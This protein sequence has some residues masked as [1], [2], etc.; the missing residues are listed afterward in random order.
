MTTKQTQDAPSPNGAEPADQSASPPG[1]VLYNPLKLDTLRS[2]SDVLKGVWTD[3]SRVPILTRPEPN[4]WVR[5]RAGE[6]YTE[7]IDLLVAANA[8]HSSDRNPVYVATDDVRPELERFIKP[9]RVVVAITYHSKVQFLWVRAVG[10]GS[11]PWTDSVM[12]AMDE[13]QTDWVSLESDQALGEYKVHHS[14]VPRCGATRNGRTGRLRTSWAWRSGTGSST[15]WTTRSPSGCSGWTDMLVLPYRE[16]WALDTEFNLRPSGA[17]A[18]PNDP[19]PEGSIQHPVCLVAHE[20]YSGRMVTVFEDEFGPEPP[21]SVGPENLFIAYSAAA[22]WLT[23]LA[24]GWPLPVR[25][26]DPYIEYRRHICGTPRD[27]KEEGN[28]G[29]LKALEHFH[30][31]TGI[32]ADL[33]QAE[34]EFIMRGG[35][36]PDPADR[37]RILTYCGTDVL[38]L[39]RLTERLL[40][41]DC[42]GAPLRS[43]LIGLAQAIHR[44]RCTMAA[45]RM[46]HVAVSVDNDLLNRVLTNWDDVKAAIIAELDIFGVYPGGHFNNARLLECADHSGFIGP[47]PLP[48]FR[49]RTKKPSRT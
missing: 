47:V 31:H 5:V 39:F 17:Y 41:A 44:G 48:G 42:C 40:Y 49:R 38:P 19:Q 29:L 16:V 35:P 18:Y 12:R 7:I 25:V 20:L 24:L 4:D 8:S 43:D 45:A 27:T 33:K 23:F 26:F 15:R 3:P 28:K 36:W 34:R 10:S 9:H 11:N 46:E 14:P 37:Q 13:A 30:I 22:E 21:F 32:T 2:R 6:D 1:E